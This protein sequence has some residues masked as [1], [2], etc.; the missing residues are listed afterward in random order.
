MEGE[1]MA[2]FAR[3]TQSFDTILMGR[4]T[5][6]FLLKHKMTAYPGMENFVFS[7]TMRESPDERVK[8]IS[9]SAGEFVRNLKAGAGGDIYLNSG[10][11]L[12]GTFLRKT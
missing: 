10:G 6:D 11:N 1:H 2:D 8:I 12:A 9:E 5:Y 3:Y 4:K 7:R